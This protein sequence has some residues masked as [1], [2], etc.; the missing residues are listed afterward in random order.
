M[1]DLDSEDWDSQFYNCWVTSLNLQLVLGQTKPW[2]INR[3][4]IPPSLYFNSTYFV[5]IVHEK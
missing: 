2:K 4:S 1:P 3:I 5:A